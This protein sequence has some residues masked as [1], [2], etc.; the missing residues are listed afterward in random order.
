VT[1]AKELPTQ[2]SPPKN[3]QE[4]DKDKATDLEYILD[5]FSRH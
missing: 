4:K 3:I 2:S 1:K 5:P